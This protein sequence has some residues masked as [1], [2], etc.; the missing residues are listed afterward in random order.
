MSML[1]KA[2]KSYKSQPGL[3]RRQSQCTASAA[4]SQ[5][6]RC[7]VAHSAAREPPERD[8]AVGLGL[9]MT[10]GLSCGLTAADATALGVTLTGSPSVKIK[11]LVLLFGRTAWAHCEK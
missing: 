3:W 9:L 1:N 8:L 7:Q 4:L 2:Y 6:P 11:A 5:Q 10:I